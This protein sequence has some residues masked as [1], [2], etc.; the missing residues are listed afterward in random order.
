MKK[1][2]K[3]IPANDTGAEDTT[4]G[5]YRRA[6][7]SGTISFGLVSIP[8]DF[9][10]ATRSR[11]SSLR[12]LTEDGHPVG[13]RYFCPSHDAPAPNEEIVRG[14]EVAPGEFVVISDEELEAIA[15]EKTRDIDLMRF[16]PVSELPTP[17]FARAYVLAPSGESTKAYRLLAATM[18]QSG[19]AGIATFVMRDKAYVVA[20]LAKAGVLFAETLRFADELR[21]PEMIGL[22][23]PP[24]VQKARVTEM[25][26]AIDVLQ[27]D[28]VDW[29]E[30][31]DERS[32]SMERLAQK[33]AQS[34]EDLVETEAEPERENESEAPV[35]LVALLK[36]R[37]EKG[38]SGAARPATSERA[39]HVRHKQGTKTATPKEQGAR[40]PP[41]KAGQ[42]EDQAKGELYE[43]AK[44]L[45]IDGRSRMTKQAL[46]EAIRAAG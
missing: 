10:S 1:R 17:L 12:L 30:F 23:E 21:T 22:P 46:V 43:R 26:A 27:T 36:Q 37:L 39:E 3:D 41:R 31:H 42:L 33:K 28:D 16:V 2:A 14:K 11:T 45:G 7:W 9:Y 29:D 4:Q 40:K 13:R 25:L 8:V 5:T 15:P 24:R 19:E 6:F 35:D 20:I 34:G 44:A 38:A 18:E 32:E